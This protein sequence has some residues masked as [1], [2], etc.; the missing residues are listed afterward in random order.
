M[1]YLQSTDV[2]DFLGLKDQPPLSIF[3]K[4]LLCCSLKLSPS[5]FV[6]QHPYSVCALPFKYVLVFVKDDF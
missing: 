1:S 5:S 6:S 4:D 2:S 3:V